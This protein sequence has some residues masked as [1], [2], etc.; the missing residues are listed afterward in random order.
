MTGTAATNAWATATASWPVIASTTRS[1]STGW[2]A[3]LTAA[4]SAIS[5]S[6]T[7]RRPAVSRMTT[8]RTWRLRGLDA[9]ADDVD[10]RGAG[11]CAVDR[12]VEAPAERL[13]LVG[14]GGSVRVRGDEQR[15]AARA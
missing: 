9:A 4:I 7:D 14:G 8:S 11:R 6:S 2:T 10:D 5:A 12:D 13:E 3:A 15:P 1:V